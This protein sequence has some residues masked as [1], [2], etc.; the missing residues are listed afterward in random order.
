MWPVKRRALAAEGFL[1]ALR[2]RKWKTESE[3]DEILRSL[4]AIKDLGAEDVAWLAVEADVGLR[5]GGLAMLKKFPYEESSAALFPFLASKTEAVR[6]QSMQSLEQLAGGTFVDRLKDFLENPDPVVVHAALDYLK[7]APNEKALPW[8]AKALTPNNAAPVRKKAF[9]IVEATDSPRVGAMALQAL[10]DDDEDIRFRAIQVLLKHPNETQVAPLLKHCRNDSHRIQDAAIAALGPLLAKS[11]SW[12]DEVLP[13]LSDANPKV[14]TLASRIIGTQEPHKIAESFLRT[15]RTTYGPAK[16]RAVDALRELGPEFIKAFLDRAHSDDPVEKALAVSI[17][18]TIRAP[19]AVPHCIQFLTDDDWWLR[20]RAALALAEIKHE[21]A[22]PHLLK[23]LQNPESCLSAAGA[24]GIWGSP[25]ALPGLLE[26][27]KQAKTQKELR[28]E[29]L[30]AFG[31]IDDPR[32]PPLLSSIAEKDPDPLIQEKAARIAAQRSGKG[33]A[34]TQAGRTFAAHDFAAN[35]SPT[36]TDLLRHARAVNA[37]DLHLA[38]GTV[39]QMRVHGRLGPLPMPPST[40][41]QVREWLEPLLGEGRRE[42]LSEKR[43]LDFCHKDGELGRFRTNLFHQRKGPAAV[44]RLVPYEIPNLTDIRLP[45]SLWEITTYSQGLIL[46][47]G[48]AGCGK[49]TTLAALVDR[50]NETQRGHILTVEDPIEYVHTNKE[51]LVN[52]REIP[53]HSRSFAKALRQSLR[54]DPDV[55]LVGEMRDLETISLAITA[56]ET[57]HL[58]LA[59]LHTTTASSTVDRIINAFP[60]DQQGQIRMMVSDSLKAVISQTLLPRRD[61]LG[62]V[63]AY[64]IL[65]NTPNVAGLIRDSK[66]F[67]IPTAI[68]TGA[69]AGMVL[70]DGALLQLVQEGMID[71]RVAYDRA[72]RKEALEPFLQAEEGATA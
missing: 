2:A 55:I 27:Y 10:D 54:E 35:P 9:A 18:V 22:L 4:A 31:K 47:T 38:T 5:Q 37:S 71:P 20:D 51:S 28:L 19:E 46:V 36:L 3:R 13:L 72:S 63:A 14:R 65:R 16:D 69:A 24:L 21:I 6:R 53:S 45:E 8:I 15:F 64:E 33:G 1:A 12:N 70:M 30:D 58:V 61:G 49:T 62:R 39:P 42:R 44:F 32:V 29:I 66:S 50:I 26:A 40:L 23:M 56:S 68:Q 59:T 57:G 43:Q 52:Q 11:N 34:E 17:A 60:P 41:E 48:P 25:K 7:R 67:Q